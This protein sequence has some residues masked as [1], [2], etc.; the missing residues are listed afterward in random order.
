MKMFKRGWSPKYIQKNFLLS[1]DTYHIINYIIQKYC[2]KQNIRNEI[3][4]N[5]ISGMQDRLE[6]IK[7]FEQMNITDLTQKHCLAALIFITNSLYIDNNKE[8]KEHFLNLVEDK[9]A[10]DFIERYSNTL[11]FGDPNK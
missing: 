6:Q 7:L 8:R 11:I 4:E 1:E 2:N 10:K 5:S 3:Y 9:N